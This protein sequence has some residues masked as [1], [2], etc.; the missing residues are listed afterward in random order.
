MKKTVLS[1]CMLIIF[2]LVLTSCNIK[3]NQIENNQIENN[4][5]KG[6]SAYTDGIF[7]FSVAFPSTWASETSAYRYGSEKENASPDSGIYIYIDGNKENYIY[8]YGT[9]GKQTDK[10]VDENGYEKTDVN[11]NLLLY[12]K[13]NGNIVES[14][15]FLK[16]NAHI[17]ANIKM[18][19]ELFESNKSK[20]FR[21]L[22]SIDYII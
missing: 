14:Q 22:K 13:E 4:F 7:G 15:I 10:F 9:Y 20:I 12:T 5:E 17:S 1:V 21:M 18:N 6:Y 11:E 19:L 3:E 2:I 8:V 16:D